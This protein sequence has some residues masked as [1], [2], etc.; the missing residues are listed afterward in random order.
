MKML[1]IFTLLI[2]LTAQASV[3]KRILV[4]EGLDAVG[5]ATLMGG[6]LWI[7]MESKTGLVSYY[8]GNQI[9]PTRIGQRPDEIVF[10]DKMNF[11]QIKLNWKKQ[12]IYQ[13]REIK[14]V[15]GKVSRTI[16]GHWMQRVNGNCSVSV[17]RNVVDGLEMIQV[18]LDLKLK[19]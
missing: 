6:S 4:T 15:C 9:D 12:M 7:D 14:V 16:S 8:L 13:D 3:V 1:L 2:S 11:P 18:F 10:E 5:E 17:E 19:P